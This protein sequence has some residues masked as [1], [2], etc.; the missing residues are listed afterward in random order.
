[1]SKIKIIA[2]A[3]LG[4]G[5]GAS[6]ASA[7]PL[8]DINILGSTSASGPF[9]S[10]LTVAPGQTYFFELTGQLVSG[11][12]NTQGTTMRTVSSI[13]AADGANSL[14]LNIVDNGSNPIQ[15]SFSG[16]S[17]QNGWNGGTGDSVGSIIDE[18]VGMNNE[19]STS[20]PIQAPGVFAGNTAPTIFETGSFTI[21]A[22]P[23]GPGLTSMITGNFGGVLSTGK[24][25]G[26]T[27]SF[28]TT[29]A[30]ES[31]TDPFIG[32]TKLTLQTGAYVPEPRSI[33][34][35]GMAAAAGLGLVIRRRRVAVS[36]K[37]N[38]RNRTI[39]IP[40]QPAS[41]GWRALSVV[42]CFSFFIHL[43]F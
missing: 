38:L 9:S 13:T 33:V 12:T 19:V 24:F 4:I 16:L 18:G 26:G 14:S 41:S 5:F 20:R 40:F 42:Y 36:Q 11:A 3:V 22:T 35:C 27:G 21:P 30:S 29:V 7:S 1:M 10:T 23:L 25:N 28:A 15:A 43:L 6:V 37:P 31:G 39:A 8:Y 2:V 17:L 32:Y 34:L